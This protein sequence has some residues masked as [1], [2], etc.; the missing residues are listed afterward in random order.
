MFAF[1]T[2]VE[3][4]PDAGHADAKKAAELFQRALEAESSGDVEQRLK[5]LK[6]AADQY[7]SSAAKWQLGQIQINAGQWS[8]I[9]AEIRFAKQNAKLK[10]YQER[11]NKLRDTLE[12]NLELADW[13]QENNL[14]EQRLAHLERVLDFA[15]DHPAARRRL[16]YRLEAGNWVS[17]AEQAARLRT[18]ARKQESLN[19]YG[20]QVRQIAVRL[21]A[22]R[23]WEREAAADE[24]MKI[25]DLGAVGAVEEVLRSPS[26][27]PSELVIQWMAQVDD[28]ASSQVLAR[29]GMYHS[30]ER[31]RKR[32]AEELKR[33]P[34]HDFVPELVNLLSTPIEMQVS[35]NINSKGG[36]DNYRQAFVREG[37]ERKEVVSFERR[38]Q[39]DLSSTFNEDFTYDR[40][41]GGRPYVHLPMD[42]VI[43][44]AIRQQSANS[45]NSRMQAMQLQN[46]VILA[47]NQRVSELLSNVLG[48][49]LEEPKEIWAWWDRYNETE[50]GAYK[51]ERY[52]G[53]SMVVPSEPQPRN[54]ECFVAGTVV[55]TKTGLKEIQE[56]AVGDLVLCRDVGSGRIGWKPVLQATVR[57]P[58]VTRKLV[59]GREEFRCT[60]GH[61]FWVSGKGWK[62]ASQLAAGDVLHG[63]E[64]PSVVVSNQGGE[65]V[66]TYNLEV[67]DMGNYFVGEQRILSHDVT[68]R[69]AN[70]QRVP[71]ELLLRQIGSKC[72]CPL[73]WRLF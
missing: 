72:Y 68:R 46:A 3:S 28:V 13:C 33:R 5:C 66:V 64:Q 30:S 52:R 16:G 10:E 54:C 15:P 38:F 59:V 4:K 27:R 36:L 70:R 25:Q 12:N 23:K 2:E 20:D 29:Y 34:F 22:R 19:N 67:A 7:E 58:A 37:L 31:I 39:R 35:A 53:E 8:T 61:L 17:P 24:L 60:T 49:R 6:E 14:P 56:I 69:R 42:R 18:A 41:A 11:R 71:G 40:R 9:D 62:K 47:T 1:E 63:A 32:A 50:Y 57:D 73:Q 26:E 65:K 55:T 44:R 21:Q 48:Q 45:I 43:E 51:P